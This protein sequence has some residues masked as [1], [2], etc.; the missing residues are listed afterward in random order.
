MGTIT[1]KI[2]DE[3]EKVMKPFDLN[4]SEVAFRAIEEKV[5]TLSRLKK[6]SSKIKI[7]EDRTEKLADK[8]NEGVARRFFKEVK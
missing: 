1:I 5:L 6:L 4:W 7:S 2:S 3:L 8:I